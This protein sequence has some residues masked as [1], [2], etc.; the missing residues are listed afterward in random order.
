MQE[1]EVLARV[2]GAT[3][4]EISLYMKGLNDSLSVRSKV[5]LCEFLSLNP[6]DF[7]ELAYRPK[8][9]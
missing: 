5:K 1:L 3:Q 4:E 8:S 7:T 9:Q 2:S 6:D